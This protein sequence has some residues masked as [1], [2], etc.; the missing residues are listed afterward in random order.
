[1]TPKTRKQRFEEMLADAPDDA[2]MRYGLAMEYVSEGDDAGA[3]RVFEESFRRN[4]DYPPAYH[5][6]GRALQRLNRIAEARQVLERG[7]QVAQRQRDQ[8]A[9]GEMQELLDNLE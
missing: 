2:E 3:V 4:P 8:H 7:I 5:M 6:A 9:A 1:M